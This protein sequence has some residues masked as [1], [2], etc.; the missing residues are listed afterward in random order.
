MSTDHEPQS[1]SAEIAFIV[2]PVSA[3]GRT[4]ENWPKILKR[5]E[6][7]FKDFKVFL[8][9]RPLQATSLAKQALLEGSKII[10]AVGGDGTL[11]EVINAFFEGTENKFPHAVLGCIPCGTGGDFRRTVLWDQDFEIAIKR[12][13]KRNTKSI[14]V[15]HVSYTA[16]GARQEQRFINISSCGASGL[17][18]KI[19][20]DMP[21]FLGGLLSFYTASFCGIMEYQR[22]GLRVRYDDG[23]WEE[24]R[25]VN[26][27]AVCNGIYFGGGMKVAPNADIAD[28]YFD[29]TIWTNYSILD[30]ITKSASIYDGSH[31]LHENTRTFKC[32]TIEVDMLPVRQGTRFSLVHGNQHFLCLTTNSHNTFT[33]VVCSISQPSAACG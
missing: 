8:T 11:S 16:S 25:E 24:M 27:V 15:G 21:K 5:I 31:I 1:P 29:V 26:T 9:Q 17:I 7:S 4:G 19:A 22:A 13:E 14:D 28:G 20:N 10:V 23:E 2:N 30:F 33:L 18:A 12:L 32:R 3:A 6:A